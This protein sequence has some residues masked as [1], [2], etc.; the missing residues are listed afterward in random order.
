MERD[1]WALDGYERRFNSGDEFTLDGI[2]FRIS[3]GRKDRGSGDYVI[4]WETRTGW[5]KMSLMSLWIMCRFIY[6]NENL[7]YPVSN[8]RF[9]GGERF[10]EDT[11]YAMRHPDGPERMQEKMDAER[12]RRAG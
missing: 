12:Q 7:L 4:E 10:Q 3:E 8:P 6:E 2:D 5:R 11:Q 9:R 1:S